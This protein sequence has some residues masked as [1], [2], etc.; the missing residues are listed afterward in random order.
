VSRSYCLTARAQP[1]TC[2]LQIPS[3]WSIP[4]QNLL[5]IHAISVVKIWLFLTCALASPP[6]M[7]ITC[8]G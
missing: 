5:L 6:S 1:A 2:L 8:F 3:S 4:P 7:G